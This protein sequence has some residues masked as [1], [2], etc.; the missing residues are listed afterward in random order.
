MEP[1]GAMGRV[2]YNHS[3]AM[4]LPAQRTTTR[5]LALDARALP[6]TATAAFALG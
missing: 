6:P 1:A 3:T 5:L 2:G 4:N